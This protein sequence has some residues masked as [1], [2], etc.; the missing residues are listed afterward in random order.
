MIHIFE[1]H[2][3][4]AL[5]S[6]W[7]VLKNPKNEKIEIVTCGL[8]RESSK[9][10]D[11][12][13][14]ISL[15]HYLKCYEIH[16]KYRAAYKDGYS[17]WANLPASMGR[18]HHGNIPTT[19]FE[20]QQW[21]TE[22]ANGELWDESYADTFHE[23]REHLLY[24]SVV[25]DLVLG[26]VGLLH[27]YHVCVAKVL[28]D[29]QGSGEFNHLKFG[30][31]VDYPYAGSQWTSKIVQSHPLVSSPL[32]VQISSPTCEAYA[33]LKERIFRDVYPTEVGLFRFTRDE[34]LSPVNKFLL[35]AEYYH[36]ANQS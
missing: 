33:M 19:P 12:F 34:V 28:E 32:T 11:H 27:P 31:Y 14:S 5:I 17:K 16:M 3:D 35:P 7:P 21:V 24:E 26:P 29:L 20:W 4:D 36:I 13:P 30:A 2:G 8:S 25:G 6:C 10:R 22:E 15:T 1:P 18:I 23:V 9:L